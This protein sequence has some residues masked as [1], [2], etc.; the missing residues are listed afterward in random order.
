M[1]TSS[2]SQVLPLSSGS[3]KSCGLKCDREETAPVLLDTQSRGFLRS[4]TAGWAIA[5]GVFGLFVMFTFLVNSDRF[6]Y[7]MRPLI[8]MSCCYLAVAVVYL[9]G[10][11]Y[12]PIAKGI[13]TFQDPIQRIPSLVG[14]SITTI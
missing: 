6:S 13:K 9:I 4:W 7:P 2:S 5:S 8:Y 14:Q 3:L 11:N 10:R 12:P 1:L